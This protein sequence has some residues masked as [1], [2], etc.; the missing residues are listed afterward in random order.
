MFKE[1]VF[2]DLRN[3]MVFLL[4]LFSVFALNCRTENALPANQNM[5]EY[6]NKNGLTVKL[7]DHLAARENGDGFLVEPSDGSNKNIRFPVEIVV[8]LNR[9]GSNPSG[10]FPEQKSVGGKN[11]KYRIE[12][13][14]G[15][16]GGAE[17]KLEAFE[18]VDGGYI[19]YETTEQDKY[20]E[21]EFKT[22]WQ[23]IENTS[24]KK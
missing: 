23:I 17:Y 3:N 24:V 11:V 8:K 15:G 5:R 7:P 6:T 21:P 20:S 12:K 1:A 19:S 22:L 14:E 4:L 16:S 13:A 10:E 18:V 9:D 2:S